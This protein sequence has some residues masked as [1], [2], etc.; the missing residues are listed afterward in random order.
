MKKT[1]KILA[2]LLFF[3]LVFGYLNFFSSIVFPWQKAEAIK[4]TL[5]WGGLAELPKG[6]ENL[7]VKKNG[8][9]FTRTFTIEF[10]ANQ[11]EIENWILNSKRLKNNKPKVKGVNKTYEI[12]PGENES[13]GGKVSVENRKVTIRMS[14]S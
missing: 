9:M 5:N 10:D 3:I 13:F 1:I 6:A 12:Y 8:S 7:S 11:K 4:V 2:S 14:W